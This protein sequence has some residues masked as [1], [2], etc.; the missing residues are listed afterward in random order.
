MGT[1]VNPNRERLL[2]NFP[3]G[4][5]PL[6]SPVGGYFPIPSPGAFS[7][8][9]E[10]RE[11]YPPGGVR[12]RLGMMPVLDHA[13][14]VESF[15]CKS[16]VGFHEGTSSLVTEIEPLISNSLVNL[17]DKATS[18]RSSLRAFLPA[19]KTLL[20]FLE[21]L[22]GFAEKV[23]GLN[24]RSVGKGSERGQAHVYA[25]FLPG[26]VED[27][28]LALDGK[29]DIPPVVSSRGGK[30][31]DST[32]YR[33][34][35]LD[36]DVADM[37]KIKTV[38]FDL[39]AVSKDGV[40]DGIEPVGRF[41]SGIARLLSGLNSTEERLERLVKSAKGLLERTVIARD[42][43]T[44]LLLELGEKS[45]SLL[46]VAKSLTGHFVNLFPLCKSLVVEEA[47]PVKLRN[48]RLGLF[49]CRVETVFEGLE[50]LFF[51]FPV[52]IWRFAFWANPDLCFLGNPAMPTAL[53]VKFGDFDFHTF[54]HS[55]KVSECQDKINQERRKA[56]PL[57]VK[58]ARGILKKASQFSL[59]VSICF[60]LIKREFEGLFF[61]FWIPKNRLFS[62]SRCTITSQFYKVGGHKTCTLMASAHLRRDCILPLWLVHTVTPVSGGADTYT[63]PTRKRV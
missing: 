2:N 25:D 59:F 8:G 31:L 62:H 22:F 60:Y 46:G 20:S 56:I 34:V 21:K 45:C 19:R 54:K 23:W 51:L 30:G 35:P 33:P 27:G 44:V 32:G 7:L 50:H 17:G 52:P 14:N 57:T 39:A 18:L 42:K 1:V 15:Y 37:L 5:A 26:F 40:G 48:K 9:F 16:I 28:R 63:T 53:T 38:I 47:V 12:Y 6:G 4:R 11:E 43:G 58:T 13:L 36:L 49:A 24:L 29:R 41:E 3:A 61:A 55:L 10:Y